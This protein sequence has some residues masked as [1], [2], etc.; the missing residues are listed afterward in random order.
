M[1]MLEGKVAV[2]TGT[3]SGTGERIA[4]LFI[5]EGANVVAVGRREQEGAKLQERMGARLTFLRTDVSVEA[6][7]RAM[8]DHAVNRFGR[9]DCLVNNAAVPSPMVSIADTDLANFDEVMA[10]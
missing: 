4:E 6:D 9:I 7:V 3:T 8:I 5:E 10:V 1:S 2:I